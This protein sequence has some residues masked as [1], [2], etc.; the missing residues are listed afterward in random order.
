MIYPVLPYTKFLIPRSGAEVMP[1]PELLARLERALNRRVILI[2]TPPGYG[3]TTLLAQ[4][5]DAT[6]LPL[7]WCLLSTP[8]TG[9]GVP[10]SFCPP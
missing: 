7:A 9:S 6:D 4:L 8:E 1:R 3:K 2:S 10:L 5:A